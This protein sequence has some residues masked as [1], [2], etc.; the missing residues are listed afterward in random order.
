VAKSYYEAVDLYIFD[1][2]QTNQP[3]GSRRCHLTNLYDTVCAIRDD[4]AAHVSTMRQCQD[5]EVILKSPNTEA[6][7]L[8]VSIGAL[9]LSGSLTGL[10]SASNS[11]EGLGSNPFEAISSSLPSMESMKT[12]VQDLTDSVVNGNPSN[13]PFVTSAEMEEELTAESAMTAAAPSLLK[14]VE[15]L[16]SLIR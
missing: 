9:L 11:G 7:L 14:L 15:K 8:A 4:E 1:E 5:P 12:A 3:R 2:F 16:L 6:A 10:I 13:N